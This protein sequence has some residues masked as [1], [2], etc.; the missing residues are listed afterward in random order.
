[1]WD[2]LVS[3]AE[4]KNITSIF[5][6]T[7]IY[8]FGEAAI[9]TNIY[10]QAGRG[11]GA[12]SEQNLLRNLMDECI[13][14]TGMDVYYIPRKLANF[15]VIF[16]EDSTSFFN[17]F[18]IIEMYLQSYE[19]F[20]GEDDFM[21]KIGLRTKEEAIFKVS[22]R[23]FTEL[24][25]DRGL[26][27]GIPRPREGDL[28]YVPFDNNL[29]EIRNVS[30]KDPFYQLQDY[31][32]FNIACSLFQYSSEIIE[33]GIPEIQDS[34]PPSLDNKL[35]NFITGDENVTID[36]TVPE[37]AGVGIDKIDYNSSNKDIHTESNAI[38]D[39]S[40]ANPFGLSGQ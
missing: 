39:F 13:Q 32:S 40:E 35:Y 26:T 22:R 11:I 3:V 29:F 4:L 28:L 23:R 17:Q 24:I 19:G 12:L 1:M 38:V 30:L 15:D 14:F 9:T 5:L 25:V 6:T 18:V 36:A 34:L 33:T 7:S 8:I 37:L 27:G 21:S 20:T 10:M 31:Y 16:G 2:S